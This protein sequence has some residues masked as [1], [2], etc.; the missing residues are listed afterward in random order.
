MGEVHIRVVPAEEKHVAQGRRLFEV[1]GELY[2]PRVDERIAERVWES[3]PALREG[4]PVGL[5]H[6]ASMARPLAG[7]ETGFLHDLFVDPGARGLGIG[8]LLI[9]HVAQTGRARGWTCLRWLTA[10]GN[11]RARALYDSVAAKTSWNLYE[12]LR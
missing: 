4:G 11:Y 3:L 8:A 12:M 5:A 7:G 9:A 6:H 2:R 10:D 1:Y